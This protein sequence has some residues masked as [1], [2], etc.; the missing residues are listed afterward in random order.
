MEV[1]NVLILVIFIKNRLEVA[2][3]NVLI[4][5][6]IAKTQL[7]VSHASQQENLKL[8]FVFVNHQ[9]FLLEPI[10]NAPLLWLKTLLPWV[11]G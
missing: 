10:V 11:V 7:H 4:I 8:E 5:A 6:I 2:H 9:E 3:D 1:V